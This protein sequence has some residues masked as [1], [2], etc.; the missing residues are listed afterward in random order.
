MKYLSDLEI[1]SFANRTYLILK[2]IS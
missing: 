2:H 1:K